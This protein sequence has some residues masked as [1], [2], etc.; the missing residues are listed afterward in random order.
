MFS[1]K[2]TPDGNEMAE[3]E[4]GGANL[5]VLGHSGKMI[6]RGSRK[7]GDA[8]VINFDAVYERDANETLVG[9]SGAAKHSINSFASQNFTFGELREISIGNTTANSVNFTA[10]MDIGAKIV[11]TTFIIKEDGVTS[12]NG[13]E[14]LLTKGAFKF[15]VVIQD[16]PFCSTDGVGFSDCNGEVG[17]FI[18]FQ[19]QVAGKDKMKRRHGHN[20]KNP[21][22]SNRTSEF[23]LGNNVT[24]I[25]PA[26]YSVDDAWLTM[27]EGYPT[28]E[29]AS[30]GEIFTMRFS[31]FDNAVMV[32]DPVISGFEDSDAE[33]T[34]SAAYSFS[35][36]ISAFFLF[37]ALA[38]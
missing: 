17:E 38:L 3:L 4:T 23:E 35:F 7:S 31:R 15:N 1:R 33:E 32:Y 24:L 22:L 20:R 2:P 28:L 25:M 37:L 30:R 26:V 6:I 21:D 8:A 16:W 11:V 19:I 14:L 12:I 5:K 10:L 29:E 9:K 13:S 34:V 27:P 18:D 36:S